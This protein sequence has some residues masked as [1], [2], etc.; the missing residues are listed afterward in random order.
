LKKID[1]HIHTVPTYCDAAFVFSLSKLE[2]YVSNASLDAIAVTN[3]NVFDRQQFEQIA[4]ALQITV[5]PGIEVSLN[6]G[7]VLVIGDGKDLI[8]FETKAA[9]VANKNKKTGDTLSAAEVGGIFGDLN[10]Y[11]VIPHYEKKP[12]IAGADLDFLKDFISAGEVDSAKKFI[13][14][15]KGPAG[16]TPVLF[17]DS[18][19]S[20]MLAAFPTRQTYVDCG[21]VSFSSLKLCLRD[22]AK[23]ALTE[24]DGNG[25]FKVFDDGQMLS[26]GLNILLGERSTGKTH[27]LDRIS[28]TIERTKYIKQFSLVQA[29]EAAT[30][31]EFNDSVS[32]ERSVFAEDYLASFRKVINDVVNIDLIHNDQLVAKY[33]ESLLK[34][35][36]EAEKKDAFSKATLFDETLFPENDDNT[37]TSLIHSVQQLIENIE[38]RPIIEKHVQLDA[39]KALACELI[40]ILRAKELLKRK[41][42]SVNEMVKDIK[43]RLKLKTAATQIEDVDLYK[44][45]LEH[46]EIKK[47]AEVTTLLQQ[48]MTIRDESIQGFRVVA[49]RKPFT[50][51]MEIKKVSKQ[52]IGFKD[53]F[54]EYDDPHKYLR[55]LKATEGLTPSEFYKYF[56]MIDYEILNKDG[57]KVS[58][59]ERSEFRLLQEIKDAQKYDILLIDEP[60]SSFDNIFLKGQVNQIIKE[61]AENMPVVVVT[62]NSTVGASIQPD[63]ILHTSKEQGKGGA[64]YKL[65]SG[66]P[67]DKELVCMDGSRLKNFDVMMNALEA[68]S[69]TYEARRQGYESIKN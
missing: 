47:F 21:N 32:K 10:K 68:G 69:A 46:A 67:S 28:R 4:A 11:L 65:H 22:K 8:D 55:A 14:L 40:E 12:A 66:Y 17:S 20:D 43:G 36:D 62:H 29:D 7:Q 50:G 34:S 24:K 31:K 52:N 27:T 59:G 38:Y 18:R 44:V 63:F 16:V 41:E 39:L 33:I 64:T 23:V 26:T 57:V 58:G 48:E 13:R 6:H 2:D 35:A 30:E 61:I 5:L 3:H 19:M 60:E 42:K 1:L 56:V 25:L 37:L 15:T 49:K 54:A 51:A 45:K 53:A 9:K